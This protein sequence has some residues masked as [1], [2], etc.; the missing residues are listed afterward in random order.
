MTPPPASSAAQ[1]RPQAAPLLSVITPTYNEAENIVGLLERVETALAGITYEIIVVDDDSPD[2]T[3]QLAEAYAE[4]HQRVRVLRRFHDKGLSP[5]VLAGMELAE[6]RTLGVIDADG[7]HDEAILAAMAERVASGDADIC[8]GSRASDGGSYGDW[9]RSR[10]LVSWVATLIARLFLRVPLSD[11][12]S[13]YFVISREAF[14]DAAP[15]VNPQGFKILLEFLGRRP[16]PEG[17]RDGLHVPQPNR[18]RDQAELVGDP[19]LPAG[20]VRPALRPRRQASAAVVHA[21]RPVRRRRQLCGDRHRRGGRPR[22]DLDGIR[23]D[24]PAAGSRAR[25]ANRPAAGD[26]RRQQ[27]VHVLGEPLPGLTPGGGLWA[28]LH[29]LGVRP[30]DPVCDRQV[31]RHHQPGRG[32]AVPGGRRRPATAGGHPGRLPGQLLPQRQPHLAPT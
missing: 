10:R 8:V 2:E 28:V 25:R 27:L 9:S 15:D 22:L 11:P 14:E 30:D 1:P 7:Q 31:A 16:P 17:G 3:W 23:G 5:A 26:L 20:G 12:M 29:H 24:R 21:G 13:G 4:D 32:A 19:V 6:G 18:R